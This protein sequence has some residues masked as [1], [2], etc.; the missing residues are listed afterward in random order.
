MKKKKE[1]VIGKIINE[2]LR[3]QGLETPLHEHRLI[4][5][6]PDAAG[7][8]VAR[9]TG[10]IFIKNEI[11]VVEIKS[12]VIRSE[13]M[14]RRSELVKKLNGMAGAQVIRDINLI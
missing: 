4:N 11:L 9:M 2:Y 7:E 8:A 13:V 5:D 1:I 10:R 3:V 14:L 6:W 12:P